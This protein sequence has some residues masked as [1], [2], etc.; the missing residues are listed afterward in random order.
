MDLEM[1]LPDLIHAK[2]SQLKIAQ[3]L[4]DRACRLSSLCLFQKA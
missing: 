4:S 1:F 2:I 3:A